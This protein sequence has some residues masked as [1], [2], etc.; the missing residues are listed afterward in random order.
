MT[1]N[2]HC[3][4]NADDIV[5]LMMTTMKITS[6]GDTYALML[7]SQTKIYIVVMCCQISC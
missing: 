3:P 7:A 6:C 2:C 1:V 5:F 4:T